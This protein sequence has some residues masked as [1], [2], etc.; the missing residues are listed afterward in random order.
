[1]TMQKL[2]TLRAEGVGGKAMRN[3]RLWVLLLVLGL[4]VIQL[5]AQAQPSG[6]D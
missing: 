6:R 5:S 3:H 2:M 4:L 1:M